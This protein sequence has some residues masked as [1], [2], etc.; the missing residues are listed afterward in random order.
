[1]NNETDIENKN[2]SENEI[3]NQ[4]NFKERSFIIK[5]IIQRIGKLQKKEKMH[6]L[7]IFKSHKIDFTKNSN[8]Y[9][10][11]CFTVSD[12]VIQKIHDCLELIEKNSDLIKDNERKRSELISFY[13]RILEEHI[14]DTRKRKKLEYIKTLLL[15]K[16]S[17]IDYNISRI[18]KIKKKN[19][20][21]EIDDSSI[22]PDN[23]VKQYIKSLFKF[24]KDSVHARIFSHLKSMQSKKTKTIIYEKDDDDEYGYCPECRG[25]GEGMWD[26]STCRVCGGS[27]E[28]K[29]NEY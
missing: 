23:L 25:S 22:E 15:K 7:N 1:M 18:I 2:T 10:I 20:Q 9:F 13:K 14:Q 21:F 11:N 19:L 5:D 4:T 27:G 6:I 26:G 12:N 24:K 28:L 17:N 16:I 3:E 8:G 29:H